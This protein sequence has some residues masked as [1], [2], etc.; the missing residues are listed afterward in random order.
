[1]DRHACVCVCA[2]VRVC[3]C[4]KPGRAYGF[5]SQVDVWTCTRVCSSWQG[6]WLQVSMQH[7]CMTVCVF[8]LI[9]AGYM[10]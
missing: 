10:A 8:V 5:N 6:T 9:V 7:A 2:C 1:V 3:V 4:A